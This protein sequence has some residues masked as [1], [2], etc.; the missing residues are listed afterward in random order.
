ML[1]VT[2]SIFSYA[3]S[4]IYSCL[5]PCVTKGP[6][7]V[8]IIH[9]FIEYL[10]CTREVIILYQPLYKSKD[11]KKH[12]TT[13]VDPLKSRAKSSTCLLI[14]QIEECLNK[15]ERFPCGCFL[16]SSIIDIIAR[17]P[18]TYILFSIRHTRSPSSCRTAAG[19]CSFLSPWNS[20]SA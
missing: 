16:F 15:P 6:L 20:M 13:Q 1:P 3:G 19:I 10:Y 8:A 4:I 17:R 7:A 2:I 14:N 11:A 5:E 12:Y 9:Q 18:F